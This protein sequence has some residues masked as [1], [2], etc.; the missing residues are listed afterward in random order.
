MNRSCFKL[1]LISLTVIA[2]LLF[3]AS[4]H[5]IAQEATSTM[6]G[7]VV[8]V[9]GKPIAGLPIALQPFD[10]V[11]EVQHRGYLSFL[12]SQTD[13]AGHF[14]IANIVPVSV[15]LVVLPHDTPDY[16]ILSVRIGMVTIYQDKMSFSDGITFSIKPGTHIEKR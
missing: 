6:S 12:E 4:S 1:N 15:Q 5:G 13:E 8:G 16:E 14:S 2:V 3:G 10:I 9:D 11:D 7:H